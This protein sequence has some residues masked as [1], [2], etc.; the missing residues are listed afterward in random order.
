MI[1]LKVGGVGGMMIV[2]D[3]Q[4]ATTNRQ[5]KQVDILLVAFF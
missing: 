3:R 5:S 1:R 4:V 2:E